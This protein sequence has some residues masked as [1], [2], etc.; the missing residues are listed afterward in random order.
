VDLEIYLC[1]TGGKLMSKE[2]VASDEAP[3]AMGPY[4]QA[5]VAN[6]FVFVSGQLGVTP[7][8]GRLAEGGIQ[9]EARQALENVDAILQSAGSSLQKAVKIMVYL[10]NI[11]D[12]A[13]V[14]AIYMTFFGEKPPAR[15]CIGVSALP[16]NANVEIDAVAV[17]E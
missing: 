4:S 10:K 17:Q 14:N 6:G 11:D 9:A 1:P 5:V 3:A 2:V 15:A 16:L 8:S 13:D 12:F 7:S